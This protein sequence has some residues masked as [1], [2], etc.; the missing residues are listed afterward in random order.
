MIHFH[1]I[2]LFNEYGLSCVVWNVCAGKVHFRIEVI[3]KKLKDH[4]E[5]K[6]YST[7]PLTCGI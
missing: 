6:F 1:Y 2:R 4:A 5:D 3:H 7:I